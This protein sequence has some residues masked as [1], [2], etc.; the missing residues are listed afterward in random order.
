MAGACERLAGPIPN[1]EKA[2][3]ADLAFHQAL[4]RAAHNE[5]FLVLL[6]SIDAPLLEIRIETFEALPHRAEIAF[7]AHS[8]IIREIRARNVEGAR[9]AMQEHLDDVLLAW[10]VVKTELDQEHSETIAEP[11]SASLPSIDVEKSAPGA[12]LAAA[13]GRSREERDDR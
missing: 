13:V 2:S 5:L 8:R 7:E 11:L 3:E 1:A 4:A 9:Q 12:D 10:R 6:D